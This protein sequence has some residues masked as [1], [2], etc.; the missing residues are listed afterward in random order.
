MIK[1]VAA[2]LLT[3]VMSCF[4]LPKTITSKL[5]SAIARFWWNS[6]GESRGMHWMALNKLCSSKSEGGLGFRDVDDF[7]SALLAKQL[8]RLILFPDSLFC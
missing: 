2:A 8:W 5:T 6:N 4:R 1:S 7:N 3:Y